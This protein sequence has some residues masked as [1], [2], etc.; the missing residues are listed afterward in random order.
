MKWYNTLL[1]GLVKAIV[2]FMEGS[3]S[4]VCEFFNPKTPEGQLVLGSF[5]IISEVLLF[6]WG[7][8]ALCAWMT[9]FPLWIFWAGTF[10]FWV[11]GSL[12]RMYTIRR[13]YKKSQDK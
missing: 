2:N 3:A 9:G 8:F 7:T 1:E 6:M 13:D 11:V 4:W 10:I 5:V 12:W